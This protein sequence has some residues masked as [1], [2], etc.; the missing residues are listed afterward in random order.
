M[1]KQIKTEDLRSLDNIFKIAK[2]S[3]LYYPEKFNYSNC[4][5]K[6]ELNIFD[7]IEIFFK[8]D[9]EFWREEKDIWNWDGKDLRYLVGKAEAPNGIILPLDDSERGHFDIFESVVCISTPCPKEGVFLITFPWF[10]Y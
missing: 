1:N 5:L 4:A 7:K 8:E 3:Y 2:D 6:D 9:V 10:I